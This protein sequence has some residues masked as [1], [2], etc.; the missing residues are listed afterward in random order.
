MQAPLGVEAK[1]DKD[2]EHPGKEDAPGFFS[3][4]CAVVSLFS[5]IPDRNRGREP[6]QEL[7]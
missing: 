1:T 2:K 6:K 7:P 3:R 5:G 4:P